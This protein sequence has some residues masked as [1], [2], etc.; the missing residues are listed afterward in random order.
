MSSGYVGID[1]DYFVSV[2]E[3]LNITAETGALETQDRVR[4]IPPADVEP[5]RHGHWEQEQPQ[6]RLY[7]CSVCNKVC[8]VEK[9]G[10]KTV[11]YNYCPNCGA[12]MRMTKDQYESHFGDIYEDGEGNE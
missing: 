1:K 3:V 7:K 4:D 9:W 12:R 6:Y 5:V 10:D 8:F 11:L 2:K